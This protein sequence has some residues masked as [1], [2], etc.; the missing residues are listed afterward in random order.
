MPRDGRF[1]AGGNDE[2]VHLAIRCRNAALPFRISRAVKMN[3][4]PCE[5]I[6]DLLPDLGGMLANAA[7]ERQGVQSAERARHHSN[8][9]GG[10]EDE[11]V[12]GFAC[13]RLLTCQ[14][15][16]HVGRHAGHAKQAGLFV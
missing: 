11:E 4:Q 8:F 1:L 5:T 10:A 2:H 7:G 3:A 6:A 16:A 12:D 13:S 14:Q 15:C 9:R